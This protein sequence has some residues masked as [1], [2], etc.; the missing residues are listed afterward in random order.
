MYILGRRIVKAA[1]VFTLRRYVTCWRFEPLS[2]YL[3]CFDFAPLFA[4]LPQIMLPAYLLFK[5]VGEKVRS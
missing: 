2:L 1:T 5:S 4:S 3:V